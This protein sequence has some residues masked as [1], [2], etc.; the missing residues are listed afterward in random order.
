[1]PEHVDC[2]KIGNKNEGSEVVNVVCV[3]YGTKYGADYV[4]NLYYG[5]KTNLTKPHR[6][7][8]FTENTE[9][10]DPD[11]QIKPLVHKWQGWWSKVH[12]FNP[13]N[14]KGIEGMIFYIDLDMI[15][16]GN[17]DN[18]ASYRGPFAVM[19]TDD[20]FCEATKDGYNS[21]IVIF[22]HDCARVLYDTLHKYYDYLLNELI[23]YHC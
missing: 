20:L 14:Y 19:S 9:G 5:I 2:K 23:K 4:N 17:L 16:T 15:I 1:M 8:C 7:I 3:K 18:L 12:I 22:Q 10:L 13:D 21:S 11:I 6:F